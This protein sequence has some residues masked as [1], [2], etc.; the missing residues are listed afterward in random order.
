MTGSP[1]TTVGSTVSIQVT[2]HLRDRLRS[3]LRLL[4]NPS[5]HAHEAARNLVQELLRDG[6][7]PGGLLLEDGRLPPMLDGGRPAARVSRYDEDCPDAERLPSL[8]N[9]QFVERG[10]AVYFV[11]GG[12]QVG[13]ELT[14]K[15]AVE[16]GYR[17]HDAFHL[18]HAAVLGWSPILRALLRRR[19]RS[20]PEV[21]EREDGGRAQMIEEA[22]SHV[23]FVHGQDGN[24]VRDP[25]LI[26]AA[27][28]AHLRRLT[29]GLEVE[30]RG[31][32]EWALAVAE[33]WK[34]FDA[35]REGKCR[36]VFADI[37]QGRL[38]IT[39][40]PPSA[41]AR[42][43]R[44]PLHDAPG[45]IRQLGTTCVGRPASS[46]GLEVSQEQTRESDTCCAKTG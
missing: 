15:A 14:D 20:R 41:S 32:H 22:V 35:L 42:P 18:A 23:V 29:L 17:F 38:L 36:T 45:R 13:D 37:G 24:E 3:L 26:N 30:S 6:D 27:F 39:D 31:P 34:A 19:R 16:D 2:S 46:P 40:E 7:P 25:A 43:T 4:A 33:G 11:V 5:D 8:I 44:H 21:D 28:I 10:T 12:K 1:P 9:A